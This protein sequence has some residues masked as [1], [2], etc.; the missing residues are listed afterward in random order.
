MKL[1]LRLITAICSIML[2][3]VSCGHYP[4]SRLATKT[5]TNTPSISTA[6]PPPSSPTQ[7]PTATITPIKISTL[8]PAHAIQSVCLVVNQTFPQLGQNHLEKI[9]ET[10]GMILT[11]F[12]VS[13]LSEDE[14]CDAILR[15]DLTLTAIGQEYSGSDRM[16]F[17]G[18]QAQGQAELLLPGKT[19]NTK[20]LEFIEP[21]EMVVSVCPRESEADFR[22][23]WQPAVVEGLTYFWGSMVLVPAVQLNLYGALSALDRT[24]VDPETVQV[25]INM[26][27][28]ELDHARIDASM[29]LR[30]LGMHEGVVPALIQ[31]LEDTNDTVR[32]N[33]LQG[34][35]EI[36]GQNFGYQPD[37]WR[38]WW[39]NIQEK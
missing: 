29:A 9:D 15:F 14:D 30:F 38:T 19:P 2:V 7:A 13:I 10:I 35:Q 1:Y 36:T 39:E 33:A 26:L 4:T 3:T 16:C 24:Q 27:G 23:V 6:A 22:L 8:Y 11:F 31:A 37:A 28:S 21:P 18:V 5:G 25:F 34:L 12:S 32:L 17:T 20:N